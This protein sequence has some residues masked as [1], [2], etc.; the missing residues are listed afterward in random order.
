LSATGFIKVFTLWKKAHIFW[1]QL[2]PRLEATFVIYDVQIE[3][4]PSSCKRFIE[5]EAEKGSAVTPETAKRH[6]NA[7]VAD[8][9]STFK[10][11]EALND[12]LYEIYSG[13]RYQTV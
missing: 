6:V 7:C 11:A 12:S 5:I 1:V 13:K 10:L 8:L 4:D 2:T 9:R 3:G